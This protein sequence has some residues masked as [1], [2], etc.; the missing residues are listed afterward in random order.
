MSDAINE[1]QEKR[2]NLSRRDFLKVGA[3]GLGALA[4]NKYLSR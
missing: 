2:L 3:T 1:T 4:L